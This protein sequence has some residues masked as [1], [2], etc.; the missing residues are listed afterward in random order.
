MADET[1]WL[2]EDGGTLARPRY[3]TMD[4][5]G[6]HW[7]EDPNAAIR[8]ARRADAEMFAAGDEDAWRITEH[9]WCEPSIE[10]HLPACERSKAMLDRR[11]DRFP[12]DVRCTCPTEVHHKPRSELL[13]K[14][15]AQ[16]VR[17]DRRPLALIARCVLC[18]EDTESFKLHRMD[19]SPRHAKTCVLYGYQADTE[20]K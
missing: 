7:T 10:K 1:G 19:P 4:Q 5:T 16:A 8:F 2:V 15:A 11:L 17:F 13:D 18:G 3:R 14:V 20:V 9:I 6:I 12:Q